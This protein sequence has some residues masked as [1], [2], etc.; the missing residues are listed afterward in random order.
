MLT[1]QTPWL[2]NT[3]TLV[4]NTAPSFS[5]VIRLRRIYKQQCFAPPES[6]S[7]HIQLHYTTLLTYESGDKLVLTDQATKT[8][9]LQ[10]PQ[11]RNEGTQFYCHNW[12][13]SAS[14]RCRRAVRGYCLPRCSSTLCHLQIRRKTIL[15]WRLY[16]DHRR[17]AIHRTQKSEIPA[18]GPSRRFGFS[19]GWDNA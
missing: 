17:I 6:Y 19:C 11:R 4:S 7:T 18:R 15:S 14:G 1:L 13:S 16:Q 2:R 8:P 10:E 5:A 9:R 3:S 12:I